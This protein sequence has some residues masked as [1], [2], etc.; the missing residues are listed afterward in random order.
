M[1]A[2]WLN[3]RAGH[4]LRPGCRHWPPPCPL[5]RI[6]L[7]RESGSSLWHHARRIWH[8]ARQT[9]LWRTCLRCNL[10]QRQIYGQPLPFVCHGPNGQAGILWN[11]PHHRNPWIRKHTA[12]HRLHVGHRVCYVHIYVVY[13]RRLPDRVPC[14]VVARNRIKHWQGSE[15]QQL[16][17]QPW[18]D[19]LWYAIVNW[20]LRSNSTSKSARSIR[21]GAQLAKWRSRWPRLGAEHPGRVSSPSETWRLRVPPTSPAISSRGGMSERE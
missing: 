13:L 15:S 17:H 8:P 19:N 6:R 4:K 1:A 10:G 7:R 21:N 20:W 2:C 16:R 14:H 12:Q 11:W 9:C 18:P 3:Q 5:R